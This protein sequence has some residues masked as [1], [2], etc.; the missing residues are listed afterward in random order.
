[1][2]EVALDETLRQ[3]GWDCPLA[4]YVVGQVKGNGPQLDFF[5]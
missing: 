4:S 2:K 3:T 1:M 5:V